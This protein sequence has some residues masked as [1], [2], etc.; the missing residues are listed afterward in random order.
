MGRENISMNQ[1]ESKATRI[2]AVAALFTALVTS[3]TLILRVPVVPYGYINLG[4]VA[5]LFSSLVLPMRYAMF[6][7][8]IG[9]ALADLLAGAAEYT[10]FTLFIKAAEVMIIFGLRRVL[11]DKFKWAA[12][13]CAAFVMALLYA[14]VD[15]ILLQSFGAF[16][17]S[18]G[19]NLIQAVLATSIVILFLPKFK[20]LVDRLRS[21][22]T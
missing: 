20:R 18:M 8:S 1:N 4:D 7:A 11:T 15:G 21:L 5:V 16:A 17:V 2:L 10:I 19:F 14:A 13:A 6:A 3:S 12:Y 9:S 22:D